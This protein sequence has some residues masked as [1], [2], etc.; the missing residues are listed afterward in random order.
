MSRIKGLTLLEVLIVLLVLGLTCM[1]VPSFSRLLWQN[2]L[3]NDQQQVYRAFMLARFHAIQTGEFVSVCAR[4]Q[5]HCAR[6]HGRWD[7]G[8]LVFEDPAGNGE[9]QLMAGGNQCQQGGTVIRYGDGLGHRS[10]VV[11]NGLLAQRVRFNAMGMAFG[12]NGRMTFCSKKKGVK[13]V[14]LVLA[15]SGRL[16][17]AR[18]NEMLD[19][20]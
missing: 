17:H 19:C 13:P 2:R 1:A 6:E 8:W 10:K 4:E 7:N 14:G 11:A 18:D 20:P 15:A 16:R 5:R 12:F 9:C 3:R